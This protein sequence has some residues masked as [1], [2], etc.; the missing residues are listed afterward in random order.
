M[1]AP[2][3]VDSQAVDLSLQTADGLHLTGRRWL[4]DTP[5]DVCVV[6]VHGFASHQDDAPTTATAEA[7]VAEGYEVLT[8]DGR[9]HGASEGSC[10]LGDQE[11]LDVAAAVEVARKEA[12]RIVVVGASMGAV[13]AL[14][15]AADVKD[16]A[17]VVTI[18]S[19]SAWRLPLN[20]RTLLATV[21]TRTG[22]GR[23]LAD[24]FL[25]VRL[26]PH[27]SYPE[28]PRELV[29]RLAAPL[30]IVHGR[31]D[32][33][34]SYH[35]GEELYRDSLAPS[36]LFLVDDMAHGFDPRGLDALREAIR[37]TLSG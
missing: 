35:D 32:R 12:S 16:V 7:L 36:R 17:G 10:T 30:A 26:H 34:I 24:R 1:T 22:L 18:S 37:W 28:P 21:L 15:Y 8:Y 31:R 4:P 13:A 25:N 29:Q 33:F 19:P 9:G 20:P 3:T 23:R 27:W 14:R 2:H 5:T 6:L 11:E